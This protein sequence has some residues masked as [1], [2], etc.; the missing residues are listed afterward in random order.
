MI[1]ICSCL[2]T[3]I[4]LLGYFFPCNN[5][6]AFSISCA[7]VTNNSILGSRAIL[8]PSFIGTAIRGKENE[9]ELDSLSFELD[10]N[11]LTKKSHK[12]KLLHPPPNDFAF[13]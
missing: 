9:K 1:F 2:V 4:L 8:K 5:A 7:L 10:E 12:V 11:K 13:V 3:I 6:T